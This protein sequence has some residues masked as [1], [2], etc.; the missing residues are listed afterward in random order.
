M[1]DKHTA[2]DD[3]ARR[4]R[5]RRLELGYSYQQLADLMGMSKSTLQRYETGSIKSVPLGRLDDLARALGTSP[6]YILGWDEERGEAHSLSK[7]AMLALRRLD[8]VIDTLSPTTEEFAAALYQDD[9]DSV[10]EGHRLR[11]EKLREAQNGISCLPPG[12]RRA[13]KQCIQN[14][15]RIP[16]SRALERLARS[17]QDGVDA[18]LG[19]DEKTHAD[20]RALKL[21][22]WGT[23]DVDD[24]VLE[25][26]RQFAKFALMQ[27]KDRNAAQP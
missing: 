13:I 17:C 1:S 11:V 6:S 23:D 15:I 5:D 7:Q 4:I 16:A 12:D 8:E 25:Q 9:L 14:G 10:P 2:P 22:L 26:V 18:L 21:A 19:D 27:W 24:A 20:D 3:I